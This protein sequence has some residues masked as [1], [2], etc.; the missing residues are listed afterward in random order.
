MLSA[1]SRA[2]Q[3]GILGP[4][5]GEK[6]ILV[7]LG[8]VVQRSDGVQAHRTGLSGSYSGRPAAI[9]L[10]DDAAVAVKGDDDL[11]IE[12][13]G[14]RHEPFVSNSRRD[15]MRSV[16]NL[17]TGCYARV[18]A[19]AVVAKWECGQANLADE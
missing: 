15:R 17:A 14:G 6:I 2:V 11:S 8:D 12:G 3:V 19:F 7:F 5:F 1:R 18:L 16:S 13:R 4:E 10:S 9:P